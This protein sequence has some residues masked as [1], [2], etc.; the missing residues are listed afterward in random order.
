MSYNETVL[1]EP[2]IRSI[3]V[4]EVLNN[5]GAFTVQRRGASYWARTQ[6]LNS[7]GGNPIVVRPGTD[8][9]F[10]WQATSVVGT[11]IFTAM[12]APG[13]PM[14]NDY[15]GSPTSALLPLQWTFQLEVARV[16]PLVANAPLFFGIVGNSMSSPFS[17]TFPLAGFNSASTENGGRW[18]AYTRAR[19][20]GAITAVDSGV[21]IAGR[22]LLEL[23][24]RDTT[25]PQVTL[26]VDGT[27]VTTVTGIANV[28]QQAANDNDWCIGIVSGASAGNAATQVDRWRRARLIVEELAGY[29]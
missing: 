4:L 26:K 11:Q 29:E 2:E 12:T 7:T 8:G 5:A 10:W 9:L 21:A 18:T 24:Y 27:V 6:L 14:G 20:A 22:H 3:D 19:K 16:T 1:P 23:V 17:T 28:P 13:W 25:S 15:T